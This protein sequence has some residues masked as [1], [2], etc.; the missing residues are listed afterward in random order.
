VSTERER[1]REIGH[2]SGPSIEANL[3]K[4]DPDRARTPGAGEGPRGDSR[5]VLVVYWL[6]IGRLFFFEG[7]SLICSSRCAFETRDTEH[8]SDRLEGSRVEAATSPWPLAPVCYAVLYCPLILE[9][10][11]SQSGNIDVG[12]PQYWRERG[13]RCSATGMQ[14]RNAPIDAVQ[15]WGAS[16]DWTA[17]EQKSLESLM[18]RYTP[19]RMDPV[20]RYVRIA[21]GLPGKSARDVALR[22]RWTVQNHASRRSQGMAGGNR[23]L[24]GGVMASGNPMMPMNPNLGIVTPPLLPLQG[25]GSQTVE[26]PIAYL[27]DANLSILNQFRTNMASFK[28]H[29]N[30][31]LLVQFRDNIMQIL[32]A[33]DSMGGVMASLPP[34][35]VSMNVDLANEFLPSRSSGYLAMEGMMTVPPPDPA[36][37]APGMVPLSNLSSLDGH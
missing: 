27:L 12:R 4:A 15:R 13:A 16:L 7:V 24:R 17:E 6:F 29:E 14:S 22:V 10:T 20:Q 19:E 26:G 3:D 21:A 31:Q 23:P 11:V 5:R 35:P 32:H 33:M 9:Y 36:A 1:E 8:H 18:N 28:V 2:P 30:T 34:L 25:D 37:N